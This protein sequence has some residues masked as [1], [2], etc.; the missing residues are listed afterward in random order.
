M[1]DELCGTYTNE[2]IVSVGERTVAIESSFRQSGLPDRLYRRR[3]RGAR[4]EEV[5]RLNGANMSFQREAML[6]LGGF[7]VSLGRVRNCL[8]A[9]EEDDAF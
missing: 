1:I 9:A 5:H 6:E 3:D 8:L 4:P 7:D 2:Q